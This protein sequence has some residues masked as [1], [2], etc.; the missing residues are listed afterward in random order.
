MWASDWL[1]SRSSASVIVSVSV[2]I[3]VECMCTAAAG[4]VEC[5]SV[6]QPLKLGVIHVA[7]TT[8]KDAT[9]TETDIKLHYFVLPAD[10]SSK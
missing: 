6:H 9:D 5:I 1:L 10:I 7:A 8:C 3:M 4:L 2:L